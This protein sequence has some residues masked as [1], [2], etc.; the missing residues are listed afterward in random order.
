M[1]ILII[2]THIFTIDFNSQIQLSLVWIECGTR[3]DFS[4]AIFTLGNF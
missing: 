3:V 2:K 4:V 1:E